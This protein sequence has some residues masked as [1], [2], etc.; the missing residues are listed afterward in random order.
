V[1]TEVAEKNGDDVSMLS[2]TG[3]KKITPLFNSAFSERS[4]DLSPDGH[5]IAYQSNSSDGVDQIYVRPFPD[6]QSGRWQVTTSGGTHPIWGEER[7]SPRT[8][9]R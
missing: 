6:V 2:M 1:V 5:W 4:P 9:L 3:E 8:L 7:K